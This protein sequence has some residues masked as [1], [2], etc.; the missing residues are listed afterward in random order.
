MDMT[1][2]GGPLS[3]VKVCMCRQVSRPPRNVKTMSP[4]ATQT[5]PKRVTRASPVPSVQPR[6]ATPATQ[7][8]DRC[9]QV[10]RL[11]RKVKVDVTK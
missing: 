6:H 9:R 10:P 11:P 4:R 8:D 7:N 2:V 5:A 1:K 3:V